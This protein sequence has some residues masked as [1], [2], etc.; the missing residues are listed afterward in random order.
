MRGSTVRRDAGELLPVMSAV[1]AQG[2]LTG[3]RCIE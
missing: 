1:C 3:V 2:K